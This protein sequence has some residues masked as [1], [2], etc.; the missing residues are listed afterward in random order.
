MKIEFEHHMGKGKR[1]TGF[2]ICC[3]RMAH[4]IFCNECTARLSEEGEFGDHLVIT[5]KRG[6]RELHHAMTHCIYCGEEIEIISKTIEEKN[7]VT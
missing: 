7:D 4:I 5:E 1:Y 3:K 2:D 6:D